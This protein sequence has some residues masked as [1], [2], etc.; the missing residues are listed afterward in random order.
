MNLESMD[1]CEVVEPVVYA[2]NTL[3]AAVDTSWAETSTEKVASSIAWDMTFNFQLNRCSLFI[4]CIELR[5]SVTVSAGEVENVLLESLASLHSVLRARHL[6]STLP[7][8]V[9]L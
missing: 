9:L 7:Y 2:E 6:A 3:V 8:L 4:V 1:L 5:R